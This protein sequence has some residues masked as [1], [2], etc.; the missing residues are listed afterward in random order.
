M[1]QDQGEMILKLDDLMKF[2]DNYERFYFE[3]TKIPATFA[4]ERAD[5]DKI[6]EYILEDKK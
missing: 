4:K 3:V 1:T 6:V 5:I 2:V